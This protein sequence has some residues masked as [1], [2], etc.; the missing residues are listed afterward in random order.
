MFMSLYRMAGSLCNM[1]VFNVNLFINIKNTTTMKKL[2]LAVACI[3]STITAFAQNAS[4]ASTSFFS[5]E[6]ADHGV[7]FE[8]RAGLN[9]STW[10]NDGDND[11]DS[12]TAFHVGAIA[13]IPLMKSLYIQTGL[14]VHSKGAK[15]TV[16]V[17]NESYKESAS[18]IYLQIPVLASYRYNFSEATQ[19]QV[20]FGP[21]FAYGI[22]GK[23][24]A[25][26]SDGSD[27]YEAEV[28]LFGDDG[29]IKRFDCGLQVG[30]GIT[31]AKHY[32]L[33]FA[34][35]FGLTDIANDDVSV[36]S[37]KNSNWMLSLGYMF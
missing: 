19:L 28:D 5:T 12:R 22:G 35:E 31:F 37:V 2:L 11:V 10:T 32:N 26:Y 33:G 18:P 21:Y 14:Y 29:L 9:F 20:N 7:R 15:Y 34:Y 16:S 23:Y 30:A 4:G 25:K 6:K 1:T 27:L 13:D 24:K 17:L 36:F 8:L 3:F